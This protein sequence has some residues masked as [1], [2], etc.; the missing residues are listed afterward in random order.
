MTDF[1]AVKIVFAGPV[2]AGKTT[3]IRSVSDLPP[4]STEVPL[5]DEVEGDKATTTVALDF[6]SVLLDD[7]TV[8]QLYG[9]P[10][11]DHFAF[12]RAIV[13]NGAIGAVLVLNGAESGVAEDCR[14]WLQSLNE[15]A[16]GLPIVVGITKTDIVPDFDLGEIRSVLRA[17][18]LVTP[19]LTFDARQREQTEQVLRSL[20]SVA[21]AD[22][23]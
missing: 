17:A 13:L 5:L 23:C 7:G 9:L 20:L 2:G 11:Q 16:D 18:G 4:V 8:V 22:A 19:V 12:M 14:L 1:D 6:S 3:A 10:G 15:N 21:L